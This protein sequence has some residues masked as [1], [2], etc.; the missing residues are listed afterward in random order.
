LAIESSS[1][2]LAET[3][4][5]TV[6]LQAMTAIIDPTGQRLSSDLID[7]G[8]QVS[9]DAVPAA[10]ADD[11]NLLLAALVIVDLNDAGIDPVRGVISIIPDGVCG[12]SVLPSD[13]SSDLSIRTSEDTLIL[14]ITSSTSSELVKV[15]DLTD[16]VT[17]DLYGSMAA[18]GCF[19]AG[20]VIVFE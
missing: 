13:G 9:V 11:D 7:E 20:A 16:A 18:D 19:D 10:S 14:K 6:Q 17:V 1:A 5:V 15:G 3:T 12:F 2:E 4:D 8:V